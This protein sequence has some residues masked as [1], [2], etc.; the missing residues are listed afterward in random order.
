M[1]KKFGKL[2]LFSAVAGAAAYGAYHYMQNKDN[3]PSPE[4]GEDTDDDFDD[5]SEDL[6]GDTEVTKERSYVSL[7]LDKAEAIATE[8]FHKAKEVI[9][10]SVQQVKDTVRS[11]TENQINSDNNFTD[12]TALNK[13]KE[14]E[15]QEAPACE[16]TSKE[17]EETV[18]QEPQ[19]PSQ[20]AAEPAP[21]NAVPE[22]EKVEEFFDDD[23]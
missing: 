19:A 6:D 18:K 17:T 23:L 16:T 10:D 20:E 7:N 13:E 1:S 22:E 12:L 14:A 11:V 9:A 3:A 5:F 15:N 4:K 21:E 8:A 2:L